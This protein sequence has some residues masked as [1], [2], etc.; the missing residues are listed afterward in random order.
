MTSGVPWD[1]ARILQDI[2]IDHT[3]WLKTSGGGYRGET[4]G[5][6]V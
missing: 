2:M 1:A 3:E 6:H 4:D 5:S